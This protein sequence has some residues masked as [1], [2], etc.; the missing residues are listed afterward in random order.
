MSPSDYL[1]RLRIER[2]KALLLENMFLTV[3][4]IAE[5]TGYADQLYFSKVFKKETGM[6]PSDFRAAFGKRQD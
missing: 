6:T 2:A 5:I 3:R 1:N 4:E